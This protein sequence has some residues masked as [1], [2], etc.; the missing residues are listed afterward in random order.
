M[1]IF[2]NKVLI[3]STKRESHMIGWSYPDLMFECTG[4]E[5]N[6]FFNRTFDSVPFGFF[7]VMIITVYLQQYQMYIPTFFVLLQSKDGEVYQFALQSCIA[8][9]VSAI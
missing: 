6:I 1:V 8:E 5:S 3:P 9:A 7:Q 2:N 4:T